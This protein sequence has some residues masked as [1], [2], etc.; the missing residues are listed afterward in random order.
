MTTHDFRNDSDQ[1]ERKA[2]VKND[3][4]FLRQSNAIDDSG[5]RYAKL[6]PS[7]VI[8]S[9]PSPQY[10][11]LPPSSPWANGFDT[12]LEPPL[13]VDEM[14]ASTPTLNSP[15]VNVPPAVEDRGVGE[16]DGTTPLVPSGSTIRR[17]GFGE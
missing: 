2:I 16:P 1:S 8:G 7:N 15:V 10:P 13:S 4:Y 5:G 9:A 17:R 14:P 11:Q 3:S 12:N 6:T